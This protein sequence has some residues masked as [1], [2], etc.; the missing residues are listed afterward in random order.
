MIISQYK[1]TEKVP[2]TQYES[3]NSN[4]KP[5][6]SKPADILKSFYDCDTSLSSDLE[7]KT[8]INCKEIP[9]KYSKPQDTSDQTNSNPSSET[10]Q[11]IKSSSYAAP[12]KP[13][14]TPEPDIVY[15]IPIFNQNEKSPQDTSVVT[16]PPS[17]YISGDITGGVTQGPVLST[18]HKDV[19]YKVSNQEEEKLKTSGFSEQTYS[20]AKNV[21][22]PNS[23]KYILNSQHLH[24]GFMPVK[25]HMAKES[26]PQ[27]VYDLYKQ[28]TTIPPSPKP[29]YMIYQNK[30]HTT[31]KAPPQPTIKSETEMEKAK[32][33]KSQPNPIK[34]P[35]SDWKWDKFTNN[36]FPFPFTRITPPNILNNIKVLSEN[37][38]SDSKNHN[39][40]LVD[41]LMAFS[42]QVSGLL[43]ASVSSHPHLEG[44]M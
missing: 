3:T 34:R 35:P 11:P 22:D 20:P 2:P 44:D 12:N 24:S 26:T 10:S 42:S 4:E 13:S 28:T 31:T 23:G 9:A 36:D 43:A 29:S 21:G 7:T 32:M 37:K 39:K 15:G 14:K 41:I 16:N 17:N 27:S 38:A 30:K 25:Q 8:I 1:E 18:K 33:Y 5:K 19:K 6:D 40:C